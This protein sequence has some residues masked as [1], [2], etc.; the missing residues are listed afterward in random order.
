MASGDDERFASEALVDGDSS[1]YDAEVIRWYR[2]LLPS[3]P[4]EL[5][6]WLGLITIPPAPPFPEQFWGRTSCAIVWCYTGPHAAA[7]QVLE[8]IRSFGSPLVGLH[9]MPFTMLQSA[10]AALYPSGLQWYWR[11]DMFPTISDE[12]IEIHRRFGARLPTGHATMHLYLIDG[13]A[14]RVP[15]DA[16][17]SPTG[18]ADG[19]GSSSASTPTRRTPSSSRSG[20]ATTGRSFIPPRPAA[21]TSTS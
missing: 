11:A 18:T 9:E 16:P 5:S 4:E 12:A 13:A 20:P 8:P 17:A 6:G 15:V 21:P 2:E 1:D 10:F 19:P 3:L 14:A 7:D